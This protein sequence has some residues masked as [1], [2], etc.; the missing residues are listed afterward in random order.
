MGDFCVPEDEL[1]STLGIEVVQARGETFQSLYLEPNSPE[2]DEEIHGDRE[3][4]ESTDLDERTHR[5]TL[6]ACLAVR[7]WVEV[8][9]LGAFSVNFLSVGSQSGL[10]VCHSSK[11][12]RL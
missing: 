4:F 2:V 11:P 3:L 7:T 5:Q 12:V 6:C 10:G 9:R 1:R 8:E